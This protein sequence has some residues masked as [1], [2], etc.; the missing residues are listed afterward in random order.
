MFSDLNI[1]L[2]GLC[3]TMKLIKQEDEA[4]VKEIDKYVKNVYT[5]MVMA[6]ENYQRKNRE[7]Y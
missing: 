1:C 5:P 6:G 3:K 7:Q 2:S 4:L